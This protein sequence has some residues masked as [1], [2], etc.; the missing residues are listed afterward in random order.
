MQFLIRPA[1]D[2]GRKY[3]FPAAW[4]AVFATGV[5]LGEPLPS[6]DVAPYLSFAPVGKAGAVSPD[7]PEFVA[8][9]AEPAS[10][11][12]LPPPANDPD[13]TFHHSFDPSMGHGRFAAPGNAL[14]RQVQLRPVSP[15]SA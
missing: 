5:A 6:V 1:V 14:R 10:L 2:C 13:D 15:R 9:N 8:M 7:F 3:A 11:T 12:F 4:V